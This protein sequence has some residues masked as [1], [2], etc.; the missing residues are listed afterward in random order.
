MSFQQ[1][2][3][4]RISG[5]ITGRKKLGHATQVSISVDRRVPDP[6]SPLG[7][8]VIDTD[9]FVINFHEK[10]IQDYVET[11]NQED[12][13]TVDGNMTSTVYTPNGQ[14]NKVSGTRFHAT[15]IAAVPREHADRIDRE[16]PHQKAPPGKPPF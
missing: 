14:T 7:W 15:A 3:T 12:F 2:A 5:R 1:S 6:S 8:K 16:T 11:L 13:V 4:C 9:H 10:A